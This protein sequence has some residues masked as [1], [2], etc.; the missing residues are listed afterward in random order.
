MRD[1][2]AALEARDRV[3]ARLRAE[4]PQP[5]KPLPPELKAEILATMPPVEVMERELR[6]MMENGGIPAREVLADL[7][8]EFGS[9]KT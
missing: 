7:D 6:D 4:G 3:I 9:L 5:L 1:E 2:K 8:R